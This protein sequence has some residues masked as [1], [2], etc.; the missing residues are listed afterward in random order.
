MK[1]GEIFKVMGKNIFVFL[2]GAAAGIAAVILFVLPA[3]L[4]KTGQRAGLGIIALAPVLFILYGIMGVAFGGFGTII[5]YN[6][7]KFI[8]KRHNKTDADKS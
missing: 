8:L 2:A 3:A 5:V 1:A 7:I 6:I 4:E